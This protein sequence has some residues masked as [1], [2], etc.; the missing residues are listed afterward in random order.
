MRAGQSL[1]VLCGVLIGMAVSTWVTL[2][3]Q[4]PSEP[5]APPQP[6]VIGKPLET[7]TEPPASDIT[8]PSTITAEPK[9]AKGSIQTAMLQVYRWPFAQPT[10]LEEVRLHLKKTLG[11]QVVLDLAALER[12]DVKPEDQVQLEIDGVRLKTSL[13]LLLDQVGMTYRV[14][15]E[16]D[17]LVLT[18]KEGSDD[19]LAKMQAEIRELHRDIHAIQDSIDDLTDLL[20][21]EGLDLQMRKPTIIEEMPEQQDPKEKKPAPGA[22]PT[23]PGPSTDL[24][25]PNRHS[26]GRVK[27][28]PPTTTNPPAEDPP[29]RVPLGRPRKRA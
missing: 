1:I 21:P 13:Q 25:P 7:Q 10:S 3:A 27:P 14:V 18:D 20:I 5:K 22:E 28:A 17:L 16:D 26:G 9:T 19:P 29:T 2:R 6:V 11:V 12:Q 8:K 23:G 4:A 24:H 15:P